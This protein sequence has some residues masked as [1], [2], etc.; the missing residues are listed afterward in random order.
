MTL[1]EILVVMGIISFLA[2]LGVV[3][4]RSQIFKGND[5]RRKSDLARIQVAVEEY[6]KDND[7]YPPEALV[8]C[9]PG[10]GLTPY[11]ARIPCDP[12]GG[13]YFY[14]PEGA[15]CPSWYRIYAKLENESDEDI[16]AD[17]GPGR[18]YNYYAGSPN[19]PDP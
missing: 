3:Y 19:A 7:C 16:D 13:S 5:A 18:V 4:F 6:E 10:G 12:G 14:E 17:I 11:T 15:L 2:I 9:E 8:A 1:V